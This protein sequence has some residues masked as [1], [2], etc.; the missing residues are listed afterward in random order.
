MPA[1]QASKASATAPKKAAGKVAPRAVA[2]KKS[3]A[4]KAPAKSSRG[5]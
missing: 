2:V 4:T 1:K 3:A 5:A